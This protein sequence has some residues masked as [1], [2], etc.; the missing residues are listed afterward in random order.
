MKKLIT[1]IKLTTHYHVLGIK[2]SVTRLL[3]KSVRAS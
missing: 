1:I 3:I 2:R